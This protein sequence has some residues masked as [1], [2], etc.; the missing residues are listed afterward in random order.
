MRRALTPDGAQRPLELGA[1][2]RCGGPGE[3][4]SDAASDR[5][6]LTA[7]LEA[8][9]AIGHTLAGLPDAAARTRVLRWALERFSPDA[10]PDPTP[11]PARA[12]ASAPDPTLVVD[13]LEEMFEDRPAHARE[14]ESPRATQPVES[15]VKRFVTDFQRLV[16]EWQG[17]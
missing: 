15:M 16:V 2:V 1:L 13:S 17:A 6:A 4:V 3:S 8:L 11:A 5:D 14:P 9:A 7:E 10:G 12:I